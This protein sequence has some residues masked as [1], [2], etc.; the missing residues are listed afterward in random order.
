MKHIGVTSHFRLPDLAAELKRY[1]L[2]FD[3]VQIA[4][5]NLERIREKTKAVDDQ[6]A[7]EIEFLYER[8][9]LKEGVIDVKSTK[10]LPTETAERYALNVMKMQIAGRYMKSSL[11]LLGSMKQL[12]EMIKDCR[13]KAEDET[14]L[15]ALHNRF[16]R[17]LATGMVEATKGLPLSAR[18]VA[19]N[20]SL[21]ADQAAVCLGDL[22]YQITDE[23]SESASA[24]A[25][26]EIA[27][28]GLPIPD[29][30]SWD[31]I[32]A[33]KADHANQHRLRAFHVWVSDMSKAGQTRA[34]MT[35]KIEY[36][37]QE[38][39]DALRIA[40]MKCYPGVVKCLVVG[41]AG[42]IENVVKFRLVDIARC[43]FTI[44]EAKAALLEEERKAPGRELAYLVEAAK[45]IR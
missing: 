43:A 29:R 26:Y 3:E 33:F 24:E 6:V 23:S 5:M 30:T 9:F 14:P 21:F 25:I 4:G 2:F 12:V 44:T 13:A 19:M 10:G 45:A 27:V 40:K 20:L 7:A 39:T 41:S 37:K 17:S 32:L 8:G 35:D 18:H 11:D 22:D 15:I 36:L 38:Y 34:E 16:A 1:A 31:D 28:E 42:L